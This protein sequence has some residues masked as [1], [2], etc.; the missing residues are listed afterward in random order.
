MFINY[1][2]CVKVMKGVKTERELLLKARRF[3]E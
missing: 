3:K 2:E 1:A